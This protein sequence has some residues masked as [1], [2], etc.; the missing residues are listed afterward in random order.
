[1]GANPWLPLPNAH[2]GLAVDVQEADGS[3]PLHAFRR[4]LHWRRGVPAL[5]L[6]TLAQVALPSPLVG[7]VREHEGQRVLAVFNLS[8]QSIAFDATEVGPG[9][10]IPGSGFDTTDGCLRPFGVT[11]V[12]LTPV[13]SLVKA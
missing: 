3:S 10:T 9:S 1:M 6:G 2:R 7:F 8:D 5:V 13:A 4:F 11:F 12:A